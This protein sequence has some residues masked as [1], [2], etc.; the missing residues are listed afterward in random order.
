MSDT[1]KTLTY[2]VKADGQSA[3]T[4]LQAFASSLVGIAKVSPDAA[5][6][7]KAYND[8][9]VTNARAQKEVAQGGVLAARTLK[10]EAGA[11]TNAARARAALSQAD[12]SAARAAKVASDEGR[13]AATER[14]RS[15]R[16]IV[17]LVDKESKSLDAART[18]EI[19]TQRLVEAEYDAMAKKAQT[20]YGAVRA[21]LA[22]TLAVEE[23]QRAAIAKNATFTPAAS[24]GG[25][26]NL[27]AL[28]ATA[29]VGVGVGDLVTRLKDFEKV[30]TD[31]RGNTDMTDAE[32]GQMKTSVLDLAA[33]TGAATEDI[34]RGFMRARNF[35][36][37]MAD[38]TRIV[39]VATKSAVGSG[40]DVNRTAEL[41]A[42]TMHNFG[43]AGKDALVTMNV[44]H[45]GAVL[46][47]MT[48][49]QFT[50]HAKPVVSLASQLGVSLSD[51][52]SGYVALTRAGY[53]SA[54]AATQL[55]G[56]MTHIINPS[57]SAQKEIALLAKTTG[58]DLAGD[59]TLAGLK[60][61][62]FTGVL[63]DV[64]KATRGHEDAV[65]KLIPALRGGIGAMLVTGKG[66]DDVKD[67]ANKLADVYSGKLDPTTQ[68][69]TNQ[70]K[71]LQG[72]LANLNQEVTRIVNE[73]GP[74]FLSW[75]TQGAKG[76]HSLMEEFRDM[77]PESKKAWEGVGG[78]AVAVALA[79]PAIVN[80]IAWLG[81]AKDAYVALS[82]A[83]GGSF[84]GG[85]GL[86]AK[87]AG[88]LAGGAGAIATRAGLI[89][90]SGIAGVGI[91]LAIND[92]FIGKNDA[93]AAKTDAETDAMN[94]R[95]GPAYAKFAK[96]R[97]TLISYREEQALLSGEAA[98]LGKESGESSPQAKD[99]RQ[100]F[101]LITSRVESLTKQAAADRAAA[102]KSLAESKK[103]AKPA[104]GGL[105]GPAPHVDT[106]GGDDAARRKAEAE[107]KRASEDA[108]EATRAAAGTRLSNLQ[109]RY[110][111]TLDTLGADAAPEEMPGLK[112]KLR[113]LS[114]DI[115]Q[116]ATDAAA[117]ELAKAKV[118]D[119]KYLLAAGARQRG[120]IGRALDEQGERS[121][122]ITDAV[123]KAYV[124][125]R[126]A[127]HKAAQK[128]R[129]ERV[130]LAKD[131]AE[132]E[133]EVLAHMLEVAKK[134]GL[135]PEYEDTFRDAVKQAA[136]KLLL[137]RGAAA[138]AEYAKDIGDGKTPEAAKR[139]QSAS[140]RKARRE[141]DKVTL[142]VGSEESETDQAVHAGRDRYYENENKDNPDTT[143]AFGRRVQALRGYIE[144]E[145]RNLEQLR[146]MSGKQA[147]SLA[148]VGRERD[149]AKQINA[150]R[151]QLA[152]VYLQEMLA[153]MNRPE[154]GD[155]ADS[156]HKLTDAVAASDTQAKKDGLSLDK[157]EIAVR[158]RLAAE[159]LGR[160][161][162]GDGGV[163]DVQIFRG[164]YDM[165]RRLTDDMRERIR[166]LQDE[167]RVVSEY[168]DAQGSKLTPQEAA[169]ILSDLAAELKKNRA[170]L[171]ANSVGDAADKQRE[172]VTAALRPMIDAQVQ[173][174]RGS[175][176]RASDLAA[177][178]L[179]GGASERRNLGKNL[180]GVATELG[181]DSLKDFA[182][183]LT[184][185]LTLPLKKM[186]DDLGKRIG[187]GAANLLKSAG[188]NI[189]IEIGGAAVGIMSILNAK[190]HKKTN[191]I[192]GGL[193][194]GVAGFLIGGPM[195]ASVGFGAGSAIGGAFADG[196]VAPAGKLSL[197]GERGPELGI[198]DSAMRILPARVTAALASGDLSGMQAKMPH[199]GRNK[200]LPMSRV[201]EPGGS[202]ASG[203]EETPR[204][205]TIQHISLNAP[206]MHVE[207][208]ND[209]T[210][211]AWAAKQLGETLGD[212]FRA[213]GH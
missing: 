3:I 140:Y 111:K 107:A 118:S 179:T 154:L 195:G 61:R 34:G 129:E 164:Q 22:K 109:K 142:T 151:M 81:K 40:A 96:T 202:P 152:M 168:A 41:L 53:D 27:G 37:G 49:E 4:S 183:S 185:Q 85:A 97:E 121:T 191:S 200:F 17:A 14:E 78:A 193:L 13:R 157:T 181:K 75:L 38:T 55:Q 211:A 145:V 68:S 178:A 209:R 205:S 20:G 189:G 9:V 72:Q 173:L 134:Q 116:A 174:L 147:E 62:G 82:L 42:S 29:G 172:R 196:G 21:E 101:S 71:T 165:A 123:K 39:E 197:F 204:S 169:K 171:E 131:A 160:R 54:Q 105:K 84:L 57:K 60:A 188:P 136:D 194:G 67:A 45:E 143:E 58:V 167:A 138:N 190:G 23:K 6:A 74:A 63:E 64:R 108:A 50:E 93:R 186:G 210:D 80:L 176:R 102:V 177:E 66:Y 83:S 150:K 117:A 100:Q 115:L 33:T 104:K 87:G 113:R 99:A 31:I 10:E 79:V 155:P 125:L 12:L 95:R 51:T 122:E 25:G 141:Y 70:Q 127:A 98:R 86:G 135:S 198:P 184:D 46:G 161:A 110:K 56:I 119:P 28:G 120:E 153:R 44:L 5:R 175:A 76:V 47:N 92:R 112:A 26:F 148:D 15:S 128:S 65:L 139:T 2:R 180:G 103:P 77:A 24:V 213:A 69:F 130:S 166:L 8:Q 133:Q 156:G 124:R 187:A 208:I 149:I 1:T 132:Q 73:E 7:M 201:T 18:R 30:M 36:F 192:L 91:G 106:A 11:L 144:T 89:A 170:F 19:A 35:A 114:G 207:Q 43:I 162:F 146:E 90:G 94:A 59:F 182:G 158:E 206:L 163:V 48:L 32:F 126:G 203:T 137:A 88:L 199:T 159:S 16:S 52:V 212:R